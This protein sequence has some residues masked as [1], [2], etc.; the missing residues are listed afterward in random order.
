[1]RKLSPIPAPSPAIFQGLLNSLPSHFRQSLKEEPGF[2]CLAREL[3]H[4][5]DAIAAVDQIERVTLTAASTSSLVGREAAR[6]EARA[7]RRSA[8]VANAIV[9]SVDATPERLALALLVIIAAGDAGAIGEEYP[10]AQLRR[11]LAIVT[12]L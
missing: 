7:F 12:S 8:I 6:R 10:W 2:I 11:L 4:L 1:M 9:A 5:E 3:Q